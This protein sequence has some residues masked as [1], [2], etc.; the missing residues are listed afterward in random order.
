MAILAF[1]DTESG[2]TRAYN[3]ALLQVSMILYDT[4]K[5]KFIDKY[6]SYVKPFDSDPTP[7][8]GALEVNHIIREDINTFPDPITVQTGIINTMDRHIDKFNKEQKIFFVAYNAPFDLEVMQKFWKKC[9]DQAGTPKNYFGSYFWR[10]P[11]DVMILANDYLKE[12][13]GS[14]KNFK[15]ITVAETLGIQV[16]ESELHDSLEDVKVMIKAYKKMGFM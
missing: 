10:Q 16:N 7:E 5:K 14:M 6:N 9:N 12:K 1:I 8:D 15:L 11:I 3:T 2:S 4:E 13:R